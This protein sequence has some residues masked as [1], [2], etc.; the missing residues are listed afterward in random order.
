MIE[1]LKIGVIALLLVIL[2]L[3]ISKSLKIKKLGYFLVALFIDIIIVLVCLNTSF[4]K[5]GEEKTMKESNHVI[6]NNNSTTTTTNINA[7]KVKDDK[8]RTSKGF[9]IEEKNGITYIDGYLIV[10]KT[11]TLPSDFIPSNTHSEAG[12]QKYCQTCIDNNAWE[13]Y[14][15]MKADAQALGLNIYI[16]SGYRSYKAQNGLYTN[17]VARDGKEAADTYSARAGHSEHQTGLAFDLNSVT[18]DFAY[19]EEGKWIVDACYRYGFIIRYPKG[20]ENE[21]G[22]KYEPWHLRYVGEYLAEKLYNNGNWIT[23]EDYFGINSQYKD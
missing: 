3:G 12:D 8:K 16:A 1:Y 19:T 18:D 14:N 9:V 21:T 13:A 11:Y 4:F 22:Y 23:M 5:E 10:N 17:Y 2:F 6:E 15:L 7:T 20:K